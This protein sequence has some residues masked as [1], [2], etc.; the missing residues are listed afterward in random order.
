MRSAIP[1]PVALIVLLLAVN[2]FAGSTTTTTTAAAI[3]HARKPSPKFAG[4]VLPDPPRQREPWTSPKTTLPEPFVSASAALFA[5]GLGD[6]RGC[7]YREVEIVTG[8]VWGGDGVVKTRAWVLPTPTGATQ[9]FGVAWNGLVYPLVTAGGAVDVG[10]DVDA[11]IK[12][13]QE[14]RTP[15]DANRAFPF[16]RWTGRAVPEAQSVAHDS[17]LPLKSCLLLRAGETELATKLWDAFAEGMPPKTN[18]NDRNLADPYLMLAFDWSWSL[19]DRAVCAHMR[20]DDRLAVL[21]CRPL[22]RMEREID[23]EAARRGFKQNVNGSIKQAETFL[24]FLAPLPRLRAD[25]ERRAK[26]RA[27]RREP[28]VRVVDDPAKFPDKTQRIAALVRDLEEVAARQSGQPG[29]V[30]LDESPIIMALE[31]EGTDAVEPLLACMEKDD[32]LTRSVSFHRDFFTNRNTFPVADAAYVTLCRILQ[33]STFGRNPAMIRE[34][35]AKAKGRPPEEMW[36]AT[37]A[38]DSA[39]SKQWLEAASRIVQAVDVEVRGGW[40][41]DP[42]RKPGEVP[43]MRG[44]RLRDK[45]HPSVAELMAK[46]VPLIADSAA[47]EGSSMVLFTAHDA[48]SAAMALYKWDRAASLPV[49]RA[50][51][52]RCKA[53]IAEWSRHVD[54]P[55][56]TLATDVARMTEALSKAEGTL[57]VEYLTWVK[58]QRPEVVGPDAVK[59][60]EPLWRNPDRAEVRN[61][62]EWLFNDD[63]SPWKDYLVTGTHPHMHTQMLQSPLIGIAAAQKR[64]LIELKN[65]GEVGTVRIRD[66]GGIEFTMPGATSSSTVRFKDDPLLPQPGVVVPVRVCDVAAWKLS[67]VDGTPLFELY[68]P[69]EKRDATIARTA[70]FL[71]RWGARFAYNDVQQSLWWFDDS[72]QAR[73]TFS[74]LDRPATEADVD[75]ARAI[76]W[77]AGG[78]DVR[79]VPLKPFPA[80]AWWKTLKEFPQQSQ[81]FDAKTKQTT[82]HTSYDQDGLIWQA[83]ERLE[84]GTWKCY[85]GFVARYVVAQVPADEIELLPAR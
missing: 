83:E 24:G 19:F 31:K 61:V 63:S 75:A 73:M 13:D 25:Q 10:D 55:V 68:W 60:F 18:G 36:Y 15:R 78:D 65:T 3:T 30:G 74:P 81:S 52:E 57:S 66:R 22:E 7:E 44:E 28:V 27:Q 46:R 62:A 40:V 43:A 71:G 69:R 29:G 48:T 64:V 79:V 2:A 47:P 58:T 23:A 41:S 34:Y 77:L 33:S 84:A 12:T 17:M 80:P 67:A 11:L 5:Q 42:R 20:G 70:A 85:Y 54:H 49:L 26:E 72:P 35:W 50:Q 76:F 6:P 56:Q 59:I 82:W 45:R 4:D 14:Q 21:S 32:R 39:T 16:T 8:S 37:L 9:R 51:I 38:D 53:R 1:I